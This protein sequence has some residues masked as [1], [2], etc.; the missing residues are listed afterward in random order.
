[1]Y[2]GNLPGEVGDLENTRCAECGQ[3]LVARYGYFSREYRVT[4]DGRCPSCDATVPGRWDPAFHPQRT[5]RPFVPM[6]V[7][8]DP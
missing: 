2:A 4:Q 1:V 7:R 8:S 3:V 6:L 5:S